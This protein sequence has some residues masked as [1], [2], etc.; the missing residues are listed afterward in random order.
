[1]ELHK[2]PQACLAIC[3]LWQE[4]GFGQIGTQKRSG[5]LPIGIKAN[6]LFQMPKI[7]IKQRSL[8]F[9]IFHINNR[10][11]P[12]SNA[13][14]RMHYFKV[15]FSSDRYPLECKCMF[16]AMPSDV[17][18]S[19]EGSGTERESMCGMAGYTQKLIMSVL[20]IF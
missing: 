8:H 12:I 9:N 3:V 5:S 11:H 20:F 13:S 7:K 19:M 17:F 18:L 2:A 15:C 4:F 14:Q 16:L 10:Q 6:V 1:M